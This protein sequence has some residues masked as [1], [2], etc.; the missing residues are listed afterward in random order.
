MAAE[1]GEGFSHCLS[2]LYHWLHEDEILRIRIII[3]STALKKSINEWLK[4]T[5]QQI[6]TKKHTTADKLN[7]IISVVICIHV[8][9]FRA[10]TI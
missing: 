4:Q 3:R 9:L 8:R 7:S 10:Y 5:T 1:E 2:L 6:T